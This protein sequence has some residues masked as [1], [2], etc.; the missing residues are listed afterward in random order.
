MQRPCF[1]RITTTTENVPNHETRRGHLQS[2]SSSKSEKH[3]RSDFVFNQHRNC[4]QVIKFKNLKS[5]FLRGQESC[6]KK[7]N[8]K[9]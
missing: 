4:G 7:V 2:R 8:T 1:Y 3:S 9:L 5:N 6:F